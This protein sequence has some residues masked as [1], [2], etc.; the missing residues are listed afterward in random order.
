MLDPKADSLA[1]TVSLP[2][3]GVLR[4]SSKPLGAVVELIAALCQS[5]EAIFW[6]VVWR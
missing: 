6:W 2:A 5:A 1:R 3:N 4:M